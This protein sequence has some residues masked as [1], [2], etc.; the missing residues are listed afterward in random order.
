VAF[1]PGGVR[2]RLRFFPPY[3]LSDIELD[4]VFCGGA[5]HAPRL[6]ALA[7][8]GCAPLRV[9]AELFVR[10][11]VAL[12]DSSSL[13][14]C[15]RDREDHQEGNDAAPY[16][17]KEVGKWDRNTD[18]L[19]DVN[20]GNVV[21]HFSGYAAGGMARIRLYDDVFVLP[22]TGVRFLFLLSDPGLCLDLNFS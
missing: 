11:A 18:C 13:A 17:P 5:I 3:V 16:F 2:P 19:P 21:G 12:H 6:L 8:F 1:V 15:V 4:D 10:A 22:G 14:P 7:L 9:D 20:R